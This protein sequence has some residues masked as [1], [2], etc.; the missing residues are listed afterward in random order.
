MDKHGSKVI[1]ERFQLTRRDPPAFFP[2]GASKSVQLVQQ[3]IAVVKVPLVGKLVSSL[4]RFWGFARGQHVGV[5]QTKLAF[6]GDA[7]TARFFPLAGCCIHA[8]PARMTGRHKPCRIAG[9]KIPQ[10]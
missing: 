9:T 6:V 4:V 5:K 10:G 3:G 1:Q 7:K 2:S 8:H